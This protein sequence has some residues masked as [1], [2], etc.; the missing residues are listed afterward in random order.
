[1]TDHTARS[2]DSL[3]SVMAAIKKEGKE[4]VVS[5]DGMYLE[6]NKATY[7]LCD[8]ELRRTEK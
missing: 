8:G 4:K 6:T 5:F 3:S 2:W 1:M 7:G